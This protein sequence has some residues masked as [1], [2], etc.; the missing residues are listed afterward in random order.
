ME[1]HLR[2]DAV[3]SL[4]D[5]FQSVVILGNGLDNTHRLH[6]DAMRLRLVLPV[7]VVQPP[8]AK[9]PNDAIPVGIEHYTAPLPLEAG[10]AEALAEFLCQRGVRRPLLWFGERGDALST[11]W[12]NALRV[13]HLGDEEIFVERAQER[14]IDCADL[15]VVDDEATAARAR[16][17]YGKAVSV[18]VVANEAIDTQ[19]TLSRPVALSDASLGVPL[20]PSTLHALCHRLPW[21]DFHIAGNSERCDA[22]WVNLRTHHNVRDHGALDDAVVASMLNDATAILL[23]CAASDDPCAVAAA[24]LG[25]RGTNAVPVI[26]SA[27]LGKAAGVTVASSLDAFDDHLRRAWAFANL[28]S[29][30]Q[31]GSWLKC[32]VQ[33]VADSVRTLPASRARSRLVPSVP[34]DM[35]ISLTGRL[36]HSMARVC[37]LMGGMRSLPGRA[38]LRAMRVRTFVTLFRPL[39]RLLPARLRASLVLLLWG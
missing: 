27:A 22:D 35:D 19:A 34:P 24:R 7:V 21:W 13:M 5:S 36:G 6:R 10:D 8:N 37:V 17:E 23:P 33:A 3:S 31:E 1:Q 38:L 15:I 30:T 28:T 32:V 39:W 4:I 26:V 16:L 20:D 25:E 9:W 2:S 11:I 12:P 18:A 29:A 14:P